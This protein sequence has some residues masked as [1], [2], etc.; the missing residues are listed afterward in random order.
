MINRGG[1]NVYPVEVENIL[2]LH[3][4]ILDIAVFGIPD[5]VL[6]EIVGCAIVPLSGDE[7]ITL[8]EIQAFCRNQL[9]DYKIP[10]KMLLVPDLPRNPGGK[11]IKEKITEKF[12]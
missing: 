4:K 6:G 9:A 5:P 12:L 2:H 7:G 3:P 10:Q 8:S 11:V 1:E